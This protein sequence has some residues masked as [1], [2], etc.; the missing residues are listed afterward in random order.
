[1]QHIHTICPYCGVGC[2][3]TLG[4]KDGRIVQAGPGP[5]PS[6]NGPALCAKGRYGFDFVAHPDRLRTPLVRQGAKLVPATWD[7][8][9]S[10]VAGRLADIAATH[11]PSAVGGFS[12]ARCT[13]E[14][15]YLFQKLFRAGLG[16]NNIDHCAR[17]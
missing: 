9:L 13:N 4:V 17:L 6:V 14:E 7:E 15:N 10:L 12:S 5:A 1:M 2:S 8:A 16:S 11:G 3:L